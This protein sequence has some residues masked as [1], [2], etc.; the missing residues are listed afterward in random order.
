MKQRNYELKNVKV[1]FMVYWRPEDDQQE[2][3]VVLPEV[4]FGRGVIEV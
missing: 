1:N 4:W 3:L 2:V